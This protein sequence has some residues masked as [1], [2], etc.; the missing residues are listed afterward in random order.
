MRFIDR[1][2]PLAMPNSWNWSSARFN[3]NIVWNR[4]TDVNKKQS[5]KT[6]HHPTT[7]I[8]PFYPNRPNS[9]MMKN[10]ATCAECDK[11]RFNGSTSES[12]THFMVTWRRNLNYFSSCCCSFILFFPS[13]RYS[14]LM[15]AKWNR[16]LN[17]GCESRSCWNEKVNT[18]HYTDSVYVVC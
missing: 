15:K 1:R 10:R 6:N 3:E 2:Q 14:R 9:Q 7:S 17:L 18:K 12:R 13:S 11:V 4:Q 16:K 5:K 8:E